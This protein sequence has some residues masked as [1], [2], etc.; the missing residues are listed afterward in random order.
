M[1]ESDITDAVEVEDITDAVRVEDVTDAVLVEDATDAV[2]VDPVTDAV[3][4]GDVTD[5]VGNWL[6]RDNEAVEV[7]GLAMAAWWQAAHFLFL[8]IS[9]GPR[10]RGRR[11][12]RG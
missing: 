4:F 8:S 5:T 9:A 3:V 7:A 2:V 10:W 6:G 1:A 11:V 12:G